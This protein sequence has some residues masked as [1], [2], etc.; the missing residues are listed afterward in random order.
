MH[1]IFGFSAGMILGV[2]FAPRSG[3]ASRG[4]LGSV[5]TGSAD[6]VKRQTVELRENALD[7]VDRGR[8]LVQRQVDKLNGTQTNFAEFYQR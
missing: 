1:F 6:Y 4:H 8:D 2:L 5:A 3:A 7:V